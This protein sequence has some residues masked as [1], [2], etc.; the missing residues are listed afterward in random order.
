M[1]G[2]TYLREGGAI[3][4]FK[5]PNRLFATPAAWNKLSVRRIDTSPPAQ[6][7]IACL[8]NPVHRRLQQFLAPGVLTSVGNGL[9]PLETVLLADQAWAP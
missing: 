7:G 9:G 1:L 2:A 8:I 3:V 5:G 6:Q 4:E